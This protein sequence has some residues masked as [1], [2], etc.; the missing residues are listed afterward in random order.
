MKDTEEDTNK[1][2][3]LGGSYIGWINIVKLSTLPK[4]IYRFNA[5]PTK[6]PVIFFQRN[7]TDNTKIYGNAHTQRAKAV[8]RKKDKPGDNILP[9]FMMY[10]KAIGTKT[11]RC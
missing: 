3:F 8:L 9:D 7:R 2:K 5:I 4:A 1:W 6:I 11:V 10:Y